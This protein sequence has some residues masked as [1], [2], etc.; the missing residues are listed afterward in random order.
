MITPIVARWTDWSGDGLQ[1]LALSVAEDG[2]A[3]AG[4]V[5]GS[6][7]GTPFAAHYL[8]RCR[9]D[10]QVCSLTVEVIGGPALRLNSRE[11]GRWHDERDRPRPELDGI[12]DVDLSV[13]PFTNTLPIRRLG[14]AAGQ[15]CEIRALYVDFP[16]LLVSVDAQRYTCLEPMRRYRYEAVDGSFEREIEVDEHGLVTTYPGLFRRI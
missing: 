11:G 7:A 9:P 1:H 2:I 13:T 14:L 10:W 12:I 3:A 6:E 8:I 4:T 15:S 16:G 5:I